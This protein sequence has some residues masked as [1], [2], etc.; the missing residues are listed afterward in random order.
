MSTTEDQIKKMYS[1]QLASQKEQLKQGYMQ[2][3]AEYAA[4]K[5]KAQKVTDANLTR[6]AVEAQ[7][8]A[9]NNAELHNAYGLSSGTRAQAR[10]AQENQLQADLT[11]LRMQQ[12]ELDTDVERQRTLLSQQYQS[13]I[14]EAQ[15]ENDLA[16]AQALYEEAQRQQDA[17]LARQQ[18]TAAQKQAQDQR[19]LEA[20]KLMA[21][22]G[23]Y[24]RL[25]KIYGLSAAELK[26]LM[27]ETTA[28][29][30]APGGTVSETAPNATDLNSI[31][32]DD[33]VP[34]AGNTSNGTGGYIG[35][36]YA[37]GVQYMRTHGV[38]SNVMNQLM[39]AEGWN[40]A[41]KDGSSPV[42]TAYDTYAEYLNSY[43]QYAVAVTNK[44]ANGH[45]VTT[46]TGGMISQ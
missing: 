40:A 25:A 35:T 34:A 33:N 19:A 24:T 28:P 21:E 9:V 45:Q 7:K 11:A 8:A 46:G 36:T 4:E 30:P 23:D 38:R 18:A 6:T 17:L 42:A 22:A 41:K 14:R 1:S 26:A 3:D 32:Y 13:A 29:A 37:S 15:A 44:R 2:A 5:E 12:Q 31:Y 43:V 10:L 27:G 16:K 20:A 39:T